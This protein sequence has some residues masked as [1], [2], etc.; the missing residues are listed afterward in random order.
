MAVMPISPSENPTGSSVYSKFIAE[1]VAREDARKESLE[2]R[3]LAVITSAG[4]ISTLLFAL[5]AFNIDSKHFTLPGSAKLSLLAALGC[6]FFSAV[7]AI[8]VN[9][10]FEYEEVLPEALSKAVNEYWNDS[11]QAAEKRTSITRLNVLTAARKINGR[12][13][14]FLLAAITAQ[15]LGVAAIAV[16]VG[17]I[18]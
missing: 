11:E 5:A 15:G 2:S 8:A 18:L 4:A 14:L 13:A 1:Q 9:M 16:A 7:F 3:A 17:L 6:F 10:P 12:K